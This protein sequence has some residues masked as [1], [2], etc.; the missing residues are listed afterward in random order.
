MAILDPR[1]RVTGHAYSLWLWGSDPVA[2]ATNVTHTSPNPVAQAVD[3]QPLNYVRPAEIATGRAI[4]SGQISMTVVEL[5]GHT[6][7]QHLGGSFQSTDIQDLADVFHKVQRDLTE[8]GNSPI[9]FV[10]VIRPPAGGVY[11][12][13]YYNIRITDIRE[14]E[15]VTTDSIINQLAITIRYTHKRTRGNG[16]DAGLSAAQSAD[17]QNIPD[18][19]IY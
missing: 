11:V 9:S 10:R 13:K 5:Y 18:P 17:P 15:N 16:A 14:D 2:Y 1:A 6:P 3:V 12:Q 7:W 4:G 19:K 8:F